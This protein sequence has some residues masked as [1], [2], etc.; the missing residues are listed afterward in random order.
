MPAQGNVL[1]TVSSGKNSHA[2]KGHNKC[3][4]TSLVSP[5]QG[6]VDTHSH[7]IP[8]ADPASGVPPAWAF[9]FR[10][11]R[12]SL[13]RFSVRWQINVKAEDVGRQLRLD[14][15]F[16]PPALD[17]L[18]DPLVGG[19][20]FLAPLVGRDI[21]PALDRSQV[22]EYLANERTGDI[23][24]HVLVRLG[25]EQA[26]RHLTRKPGGC[27][28]R[29]RKGDD[30]TVLGEERPRD[31]VNRRQDVVPEPDEQDRGPGLHRLR[32]DGPHRAASTRRLPS[33]STG[34]RV[35]SIA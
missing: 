24:T 33:A 32:P 3:V 9:L 11:L 5:F 8:R 15:F 16:H 17:R 6:W 4:D 34:S 21:E 25:L 28:R 35:D 31:L 22:V 27:G 20:Q 7:R 30:L 23:V 12:G 19:E 14:G 18:S 26:L 1:G 10:P 13:V 2:L 29:P